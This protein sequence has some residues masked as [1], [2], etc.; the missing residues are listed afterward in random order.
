MFGKDISIIIDSD[1]DSYYVLSP[2][3]LAK[4][5]LVELLFVDSFFD[6][7]T[8]HDGI[9]HTFLQLLR[10]LFVQFLVLRSID[11]EHIGSFVDLIDPVVAQEI[12]LIAYNAG[13]FFY[14]FDLAV[15]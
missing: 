14:N 5:S 6:F 8:P 4:T 11:V 15:F 2:K 9:V 10:Y 1:S 13:S 7:D 12:R 3:N